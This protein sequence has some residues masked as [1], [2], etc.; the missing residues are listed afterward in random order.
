MSA[1]KKATFAAAASGDM[2]MSFAAR[3]VVKKLFGKKNTNV[4]KVGK[5]RRR[6]R[7][8]AR[9]EKRGG[10]SEKQQARVTARRAKIDAGDAKRFAKNIGARRRV[11]KAITASNERRGRTDA[12]YAGPAEGTA[13]HAAQSKQITKFQLKDSW[14]AKRKTVSKADRSFHK[15]ASKQKQMKEWEYYDK[16]VK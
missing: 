13:D 5:Q 14:K 1:S 9:A 8:D 15:A 2:G 7:I 12:L 4:G 6:D 16:Y 11:N 10:Y 3:A